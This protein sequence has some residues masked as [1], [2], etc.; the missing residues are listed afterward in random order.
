MTQELGR[1]GM[2]RFAGGKV[3][4]PGLIQVLKHLLSDFG[5]QGFVGLVRLHAMIQLLIVQRD[6]LEDEGLPQLI[7]GRII[8]VLGGKGYRVDALIARITL[9]DDMLLNYLHWALPLLPIASV[10]RVARRGP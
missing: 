7:E 9:A 2:P 8:Q 1:I 4:L 10:W 6:A 5:R 3:A